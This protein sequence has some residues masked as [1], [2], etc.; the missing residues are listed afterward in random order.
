MLLKL[1]K[2]LFITV[3]MTIIV[4]RVDDNDTKTTWSQAIMALLSPL[5][6]FGDADA[7]R[8][9]SLGLALS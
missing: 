5:D 3:N 6:K 1:E 7:A 2:M 9:S 4:R 8:T